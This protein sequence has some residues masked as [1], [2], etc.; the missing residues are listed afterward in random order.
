MNRSM[1]ATIARVGVCLALV[2]AWFV[3]AA[4]EVSAGQQPQDAAAAQDPTPRRSYGARGVL[5][6]LGEDSLKTG[7]GFSGFTVLRLTTDLEFEGEIGYQAMNTKANGL[8]AGRL[9][10]FPFRGTLRVQMWRFGGAQPYLGGGGGVYINRF[11]IDSS[12]VEE[13]AEVG[14][15]SSVNIDPAFALHGAAGVEWERGRLHFGVDMKYVFGKADVQSNV[16]DQVTEQVF[17]ETSKLRLNG[18]WIAGG[19]RFAF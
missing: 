8:P 15:A 4:S 5:T 13:L 2:G 7:L 19:L 3:F 18:F 14:F 11:S 6:L 16:V 10:V 9:S 1:I 12:V 17:R